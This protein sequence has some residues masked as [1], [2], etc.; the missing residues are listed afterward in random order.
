M[1]TTVSLLFESTSSIPG[2]LKTSAPSDCF[3]FPELQPKADG[4]RGEKI[5]LVE[6]VDQSIQPDLLC[7]KNERTANHSKTNQVVDEKGTLP[8][9]E[10]TKRLSLL[11]QQRQSGLLP[12]SLVSVSLFENQ[13][14]RIL[15]HL[16]NFTSS[17]HYPFTNQL[18]SIL[19]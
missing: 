1:V 3:I 14:K 5:H 10:R 15:T 8:T 4:S 16:T 2:V 19:V 7:S 9:S 13:P 18:T 11:I 12:V 17:L 6:I